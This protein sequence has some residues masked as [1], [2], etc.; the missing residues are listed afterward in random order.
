MIERN[1]R[2]RYAI[3]D[4]KTGQCRTFVSMG[5]AIAVGSVLS[6]TT[7]TTRR[8]PMAGK[9]LKELLAEA[10]YELAGAIV[11][12]DIA[13]EL[14]ARLRRVDALHQ[15]INS[16]ENEGF[17]TGCDLSHPCSTRRALDGEGIE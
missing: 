9:A 3:F 7:L 8:T 10:D 15:R 1:Q 4:R 17:C 14:V 6:A 12:R 13:L 2:S 5:S 16:G 11:S